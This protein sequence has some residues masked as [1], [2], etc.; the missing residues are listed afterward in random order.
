MKNS[1]FTFIVFVLLASCLIIAPNVKSSNTHSVDWG[2]SGDESPEKWGDLSPEFET[3]KLGK[4]QSPIDLNDMSASSADSLEFTYKYT[5][6]KVINNGHAIEVAYKAG[7]SIKIEG[8]RY[9]LLQ[10]HFHAPS[11]HTI[12]GG[13]YP[14][15]AHLVHKSQDGQLA[16]IGVF[17]KEG[18]YNPFIETLWANIPTQKGERIVRGVTVNASALPPKDK[19]FYHYT[20]SLTTPPCT[21]GVN[22]Y[23]LKQP[24]EISSQ[25]LAKF[26]SVYS[27]N[28][29]PVQPLNKRVIKTK[30]M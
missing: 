24:I 14:M 30:E 17:L 28:A 25:Q 1:T 23:V 4:T 16:V 10:F 13:D 20:G 11:E 12:K 21:E 2:Y 8:K 27:G 6:Y 26:Q 19:S 3:C 29:R 7:S 5:P 15:E 9:E 22:W 18:Q